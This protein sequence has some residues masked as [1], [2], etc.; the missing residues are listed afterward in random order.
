MPFGGEGASGGSKGTASK[1]FSKQQLSKALKTAISKGDV[2]TVRAA[3]DQLGV[4]DKDRKAIV[5]VTQSIGGHG[6]FDR[7][8]ND[9]SAALNPRGVLQ[10]AGAAAN[11]A[12]RLPQV[13]YKVATGEKV[14][15]DELV[16]AIPGI[17]TAYGLAKGAITE[18]PVKGSPVGSQIGMSFRRT[19][20]RATDPSRLIRDYSEHPLGTLFEDAG[21]IAVVAGAASRLA[22]V[23]NM[24]KTANLLETGSRASGKVAN[25]PFL[26]ASPIARGANKA[27]LG[28]LEKASGSRVLRPVVEA[29][30]QTPAQREA[31]GVLRSADESVGEQT[32]Q[33]YNKHSVVLEKMLKRP[34]EQQAAMTVAMGQGDALAQMRAAAPERFA[35]FVEAHPREF[36]NI[37]VKAAGLAADTVEGKANNI[38]AAADMIVEHQR[39]NEAG[40]RARAGEAG[41]QQAGYKPD[42]AFVE[43]KAARAEAV[44]AG[45]GDKLKAAQEKVLQE[46]A[47]ADEI[48]RGTEDLQAAHR[49][50]AVGG[51]PKALSKALADRNKSQVKVVEAENRVKDAVA[52]VNTVQRRL[53]TAQTRGET[54][55]ANAAQEIKAAPTRLQPTL[56]AN[57]AAK[58]ELTATE[59]QLRGQG[60]HTQAAAVGKTADE[61]ATTLSALEAAGIDP[62]HLIR[63]VDRPGGVA[64]L[65]AR[66]SELRTRATGE[67]FART[68]QGREIRSVQAQHVEEARRIKEVTNNE[69]V[70]H[71]EASQFARSAGKIL[72]DEL[73]LTDK[74]L[75]DLGYTRLDRTVPLTAQSRVV[76]TPVAEMA[77]KYFGDPALDR[78]FTRFY[79]PI[80]RGFKAMV[81]PLSPSWQVGNMVGNTLMASLAGGMTP[82]ALVRE[83]TNSVREFKRTGSL[84]GPERLR[85]A[86][87]SY[88]AQDYGHRG[89]VKPGGVRHIL[90][91]PIRLG[92]KAN[93]VVDN[94]LRS[95]VYLDKKRKGYTDEMALRQSLHAMGDFSNLSPFERRVVRRIIPFYAWQKH[96]ANLALRLPVEHPLRTAFILSMGTQFNDG[97]A[98]ESLLPSY[99]HGSIPVGG[100]NVLQPANLFPFSNPLESFTDPKAALKNLSPQIKFGLENATGYSTLT[101]KMFTHAPGKAE[102]AP[103]ILTQLRGMSPQ[104]RLWDNLSGRNDVV[105]Y[106]SGEPVRF[107]DSDGTLH[108]I[109]SE[110]N[111][112]SALL[113]YLGLTIRSQKSLEGIADSIIKKKVADYKLSHPAESTKSPAG[114]RTSPFGK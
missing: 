85:T 48:A 60:L 68:G 83:I 70:K 45:L 15:G 52:K 14:S 1:S 42:E 104:A 54:V 101:G 6:F 59:N 10:F 73:P 112:K 63:T 93:S 99:L 81:L 2:K 94:V 33:L 57:R 95:A 55:R 26:P 46:R 17:G 110:V 96:L 43:K 105:R 32:N 5:G 18:K 66:P 106:Q 44:I 113:K 41:T 3:A 11:E 97:D 87:P 22:R 88:E 69:T 89:Y 36:G 4:S 19:A 61:I 29:I 75:S 49:V 8:G 77:T 108:T 72:P 34:E 47:R 38:K 102:G 39:T 53:E 20:N 16:T 50:A 9:L 62:P 21:N 111:T 13:G 79:D 25:A 23:A 27:I 28:G 109:P 74:N 86:G 76:P 7:A 114:G 67:E 71:L 80:T 100:G 30:G 82:V 92:Y 65:G 51:D 12:T 98:W 78:L 37:S 107:R 58:S 84:P 35:A 24:E 64:Q 91:A 31:R 103:S 40:Y 90:G 56:A